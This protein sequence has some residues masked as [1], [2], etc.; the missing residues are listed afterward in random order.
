VIDP[1]GVVVELLAVEDGVRARKGDEAG[2]NRVV[3]EWLGARG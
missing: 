1:N 2:A 3:A